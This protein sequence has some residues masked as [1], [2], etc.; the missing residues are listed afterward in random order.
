MLP[1]RNFLRDGPLRSILTL[2]SHLCLVLSGLFPTSSPTKTLISMSSQQCVSHEPKLI[3]FSSYLLKNNNN[4]EHTVFLWDL[5]ERENLEDLSLDGRIIL[6][7]IIKKAM[8]RHGL[9][10]SGSGWRRAARSCECGNEISCART[11]L[12]RVITQRVVVIPYRR[13]GIT[14]LSRLQGSWI[15]IESW[16]L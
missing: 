3:W 4:C 5:G 7:W 11:A 15:H 12:F 10:W 8:R 14:Y 6:K 1:L 2:P 16:E 13:F 9:D